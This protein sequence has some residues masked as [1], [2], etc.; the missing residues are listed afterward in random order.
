MRSYI[1]TTKERRLLKE[2]L[3]TG[4][5]NGVTRKL[6]TLIRWSMPQLVRDLT[7]LSNVTKELS[8]RDRYLGRARL[9]EKS[10]SASQRVES[11]STLK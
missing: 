5:E 1:F 9:P 4:E 8:R 6:F 2:W 10:R 3:E 7:L 11:G